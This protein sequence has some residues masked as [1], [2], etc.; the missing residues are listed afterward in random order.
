MEVEEYQK[1]KRSSQLSKESLDFLT[2]ICHRTAPHRILFHQ[3]LLPEHHPHTSYKICV[4]LRET[5]EGEKG[6]VISVNAGNLL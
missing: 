6:T 4:H 3:I 1:G 5:K 2:K